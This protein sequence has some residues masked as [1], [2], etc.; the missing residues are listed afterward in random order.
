MDVNIQAAAATLSDLG[1]MAD[2]LTL[3]RAMQLKGLSELEAQLGIQRATDCGLIE[4]NKDWS[5]SSAK[6][7]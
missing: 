7:G 4:T 6:A 3:C 2:A 5:L 1:G